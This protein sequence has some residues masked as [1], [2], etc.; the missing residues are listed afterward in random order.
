MRGKVLVNLKW[1]APILLTLFAAWAFAAAPTPNTASFFTIAP[2]DPQAIIAHAQGD[3]VADDTGALQAAIDAAAAGGKDGLVFVPS[4]RYR[5]TRTLFVWRGVRIFGVGST[6]PVFVLADNTPGFQQG[7]ATMVLFSSTSPGTEA[8]HVP[9][10][11]HD[12]VPFNPNVADATQN[13]FY[14]AM[15]NVDFE[16]GAGN[17]GAAAVRF[18]GAQHTF[19]THMD[20]RLGSAFT[21][22]YQ[23]GNEMEDVHF[24]GGRYGI[25]TEKTSP[26]WQFTLVDSTFDGQRDAAIREHEVALTL[27]NVS[28]R[29][30]PVGIEIDRGYGDRLYGQDVRFE[31][32][33]RAGVIISN[34]NNVYTEVNFQNAIARNTPVFA[35][36]RD[37]GRDVTGAGA[38]YRVSD[39]GYGLVAPGLGQ[40]GD[41]D[42]VMQAQ[43]LH[44]MPPPRAPFIRPLPSQSEWTNVRDLGAKGDN[45]TDDTAA[46]QSAIDTHRVLYFPTGFY[47]VTDTLRLKPNTVL[48]GLHPDMTQ[49]VL[50]D[51]APNFAGVGAPRALVEAPRGG[52]TIISGLGLFTNGVNPRATALLWRSGQN[53]LVDDVKI[54]GGHG[55]APN[56]GGRFDPY[57][58]V[59]TSDSDPSRRWSGQYPSIWVEGGGGTFANIWSPNTYASAGFLVSHTTTP[60]RMLGVSVEH[61]LRNEIIL[62]HAENWELLAP[63]TEEEGGESPDAISLVI[64]NSRNILVANYHGYRVT[65]TYKSVR[66][67]IELE[68]AADIRFRNVAVNSEHGLATCDENGCAN[69]LRPSRYPYENA[70]HDVTHHLEVRERMFARLDVPAHPP[71]PP[72]A[73]GPAPQRLAGNFWSA[74]GGAVDAHGKLYFVDAYFQRIYGWSA[75]EGLTIEREDALDPIN[76]AIDHSGDIIVLSSAGRNGSVYTFHPGSPA[77]ELSVLQPQA[78]APPRDGT[79]SALPGNWWVNGE[80]SD[81]LNAATYEYPT[82][83]EMFA[84]YVATP[85]AREYVSSDG[86]LTLPAFRVFQQG[87]SD[88]RGRRFSDALDTYGFVAAAPGSRVF[89]TNSSENRTYGALVG[90]GGVLT[91]LRVFANRGGES[92]AQGPDGRVYVANG[93]IFLYRPDGSEAGRIDV[94]ERPLQLLFGGEDKR[95]LFILTHHTLYSVRP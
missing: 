56:N 87:A 83:A 30:T 86:S 41:Y 57:T 81:K 84:A 35:H 26:G 20:F 22:V 6:R 32:V 74:S 48:I 23:A 63:Q 39:F 95:T 7:V 51:N 77:T 55:A 38:I 50:A 40:M 25:V 8:G 76:L 11:P 5:L 75:R 2:R 33:S 68:N 73:P 80:F 93:Q 45:S 65:R 82:L 66:A 24:H 60:G 69:F 21:G 88:Y 90:A 53:S 19:L 47:N 4:G 16:I 13:T 58:L 94:P 9:F 59:R 3:G 49:I 46:L 89:V 14:S 34:E 92:V 15:S 54:Q 18:H 36:F 61:H 91:D 44:S 42:T 31:N 43:P 10:P 17:A 79:L 37:S 1:A 64:R 78:V 70:V 12:S 85:K 71:T 27:A 62:D 29:D 67:A 72:P 52:A 28:F